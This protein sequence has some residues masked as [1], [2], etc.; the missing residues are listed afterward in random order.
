MIFVFMSEYLLKLKREENGMHSIVLTDVLRLN[1]I[2]LHK[3][4]NWDNLFMLHDLKQSIYRDSVC[5]QIKMQSQ[6]LV[7]K[8]LKEYCAT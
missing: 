6:K 8:S 4:N 5:I 2:D 7:Q 3:F 1:I